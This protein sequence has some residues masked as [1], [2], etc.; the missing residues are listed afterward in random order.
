M[1]RLLSLLLLTQLHTLVQAAPSLQALIDAAPAGSVLNLAPGE[2][3]GPVRIAKPLTLDGGGKATLRGNGK[4]TVVVITGRQVT[5]RGLTITGSGEFLDGVDAGILVEGERH[6]IENNQLEDVLFGIHLRAA[7]HTV[8]RNNALVGKP[9]APSMRGDA[10]RMWNGSANR[11][12]GNRFVRAR[13]LTFINSQDSLIVGN[14]FRD[15]RYGMQIVFSPRLA[16][17]NNHIERMAT[18]IVVLYSRDVT[19]R[20]NTI[21]HAL[22]GGG[23]GIVFKESDDGRVIGNTVLHCAVGLKVDAP[24]EKL[25]LLE[26]SDNRFAHNIIGLF[27]YGE[28]GGHRF[29]RNR[30]ENNLTTVAVSAKGAGEANVWR[31][32]RWDE[33]QGFDR[34]GDGIGDMPHEDWLFADRI[35]MENPMASF[36]RNAPVLEL[37]DFLERLAPFSAPYRILF[38]S[39]PDM[40]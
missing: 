40:R 30:F 27:F 37:L 5:L 8:V 34:D 17:E 22:T 33:Y 15:G 10:L 32:N 35:W 25:G 38:D 20:G 12:E 29:E 4:G 7:Q 18:G 2:Y 14:Q 21:A 16:V 39:T 6:L 26:V 24:P 13:D 3:A 36:F 31:S 1:L 23:A 9:L 19:L 11:I 28:A